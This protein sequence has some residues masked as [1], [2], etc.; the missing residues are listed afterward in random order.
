MDLNDLRRILEILNQCILALRE[1]CDRSVQDGSRKIEVDLGFLTFKKISKP[2]IFTS[3]KYFILPK[4]TNMT[5]MISQHD[6]EEK[7]YIYIYTKKHIFKKK[8]LMGIICI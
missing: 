8:Y 6:Q 5:E 4:L 7:I 1:F 3:H 2:A